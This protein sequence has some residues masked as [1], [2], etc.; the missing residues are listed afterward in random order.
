M[1]NQ[2]S[3][4]QQA[5]LKEAFSLF[6]RDGD[7]TITIKELQVVMRSIGQ[8]PNEE[9]IR[10][11]IREVDSVNTEEVDYNGFMELMA[12]K[13][14]EGEM[15][16]ELVEAFKTFDKNNKGYYNVEEL[17]EVMLQYG[18]KLNDDEV[19]LMFDETD[20]DHD[21]RITFEDFVLMM[22]AK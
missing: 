2:L 11:M 6:D 12:K 21:G 13:M 16:E 1:A 4:E 15:N 22:M 10:E 18:E 8:N 9:E 3:E 17:K 19:K 5:E 7:G 14:K 20:I